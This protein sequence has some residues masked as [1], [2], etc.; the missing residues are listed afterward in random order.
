MV[1]GGEEARKALEKLFPKPF[2]DYQW[3]LLVSHGYEQAIASGSRSAEEVAEELQDLMEAEKGMTSADGPSLDQTN[4]DSLTWDEMEKLVL[5]RILAAG[6][7]A[8]PR[9]ESEEP[10][11]RRSARH[12]Q[13]Q[14][15]SSSLWWAMGGVG[16]VVVIALVAMTVVFS[17]GGS[18]DDEGADSG[19]DIAG[20]AST[21]ELGGLDVGPATTSATSASTTSPTTADTTGETTADPTT[22]STAEPSSDTTTDVGITITAD[23]PVVAGPVETARYSA[24]LTGGQA[25]PSVETEASGAVVLKVMSDGETVEFIF[26]I[27]DLTGMTVARMCTGEVGES[28]TEIVTLYDGIPWEW[29]FSGI[30]LESSFTAEELLGPL[31]GDSIDGLIELIEEGLVYVYVGTEDHPSGEIRGHLW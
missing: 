23:V 19:V 24:T 15:S 12:R 26:S 9:R 30:A 11:E 29:T 21:T 8:T 6:G 2:T 28:G 14:R 13:R 22:D 18:A 17:W 25:V 31:E 16:L 7:S 5:G 27:Y 4:G 20:A 1:S 3:S 10:A